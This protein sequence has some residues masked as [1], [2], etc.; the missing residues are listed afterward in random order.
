MKFIFRLI[1]WMI[2]I[3][4]STSV[5]SSELFVSKI[6]SKA[7][8]REYRFSVY[9]PDGYANST[10]RY[11]V[12]YL[13]HGGNNDENSWAVK[14]NI[15]AIVDGMVARREIPPM[16][17]VMPGHYRGYWVDGLVER[18]ESAVIEDLVPH[19]DRQYRTIAQR[20]GRLVAGLSAGGYGTVN[21][22]LKHPQLFAAAA[23][24]SPAVWHPV[25]D[26]KSGSRTYPQFQ[27]DGK[28]DEATWQRLNWP[29]HLP[30]YQ[31]AKTVVPM[32]IASGDHDRLDIAY[33]SAQLFKE[34]R[35]HQPDAVELRI[36]DG[37][38]EWD[39]WQSQIAEGLKF[40]NR[41]LSRPETP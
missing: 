21:M 24:L 6:P 14:G 8:S 38:H 40:M 15:Q 12:L 37:D 30:A 13:L 20:R 17:V 5:L 36:V 7:L 29:T 35:K 4:A 18:G 1:A 32:F 34:L 26:A 22:A 25:P 31:A 19:I 9:L 27:V 39:V 16:I 3:T 28:F 11:P 10:L 33:A 41:Y 23:A 2:A